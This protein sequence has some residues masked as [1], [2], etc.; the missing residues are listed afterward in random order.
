MLEA[1]FKALL[2][3]HYKPPTKQLHPQE[4]DEESGAECQLSEVTD[5]DE[6]ESETDEKSSN[7]SEVDESIS[8]CQDPPDPPNRPEASDTSVITPAAPA[9]E[10]SASPPVTTQSSTVFIDGVLR[11]PGLISGS[12]LM[13]GGTDP[14]TGFVQKVDMR[15]W[16]GESGCAMLERWKRE[17]QSGPDPIDTEGV[18]Q[19]RRCLENARARGDT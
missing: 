4:S 8:I 2:G 9:A 14:V 18:A 12:P 7:K 6:S 3:V 17:L 11:W 15:R 13:V 19:I 1:S 5:A 10:P 16:P